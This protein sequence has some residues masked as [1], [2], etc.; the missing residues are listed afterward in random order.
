M[1][2][3]V[4]VRRMRPSPEVPPR[5]CLR[6]P[7]QHCSGPVGIISPFCPLRRQCLPEQWQDQDGAHLLCSLPVLPRC[8]ELEGIH[9][10][11]PPSAATPAHPQRWTVT[12]PGP[13]AQS[14]LGWL[15]AFPLTATTPAPQPGPL[16]R[17]CVG[18]S[19]LAWPGYNCRKLELPLAT[20]SCLE[21]ATEG[22]GHPLAG[23]TDRRH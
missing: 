6:D 1:V 13:Q 2:A 17:A 4:A 14:H 5:I 7:S 22:N 9:L 3:V 10:R 8:P 12:P 23:E 11:P 16:L 19:A 18:A 21:T 15:L 20:T